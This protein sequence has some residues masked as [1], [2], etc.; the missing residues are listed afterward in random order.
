MKVIQMWKDYNYP[1]QLIDCARSVV[2]IVGEKNYEILCTNFEIPK[3]L[4]NV[5]FKNF[6]EEFDRI[7]NLQKNIDWWNKYCTTNFFKSDLIR[8]WYASQYDD[9]FYLDIDICL[10]QIIN[11]DMSGVPYFNKKDPL[12]MFAV[13]GGSDKFDLFLNDLLPKHEPEPMIICLIMVMDSG[14]PFFKGKFFPESSFDRIDFGKKWK[15]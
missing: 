15:K 3:R 5:S 9:L 6:D 8:L 4:G 10:H 2:Q 14:L 12:C 11:M 1:E 13:N 7:L